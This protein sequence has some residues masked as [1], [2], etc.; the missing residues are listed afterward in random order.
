MKLNRTTLVN[1]IFALLILLAGLVMTVNSFGQTSTPCSNPSQNIYGLTGN[2][3]IYEI[4]MTTGV[5]GT[6]VKNNTYSGNSPSK[7]NGMGYNYA[8][9]KF[10]YFKRNVGTTPQ[11][12]VSFS[13]ATNTVTIL[14]S[15]TCADEVHTGCVNYAGTGYYTIDIQGNL[16]Y[17][18][19]T[20]NT[21]TFITSNIVDQYNLDVDSCIR[22]Q[23]AG[24]MAMDGY[25]HIYLVTSSNSNYGLF[26]FPILP[27]TAVAKITVNR[28]VSPYTATP[29]G[30]SFAGIAFNPTGQIYM[31]TKTGNRLYRLNNDLSLTF[32]AAMG[33]SDIGND[34]TS[35]SFPFLVLPVTWE[36]FDV[37][38][39]RDNT[40][41][42]SWTVT[43][44][45]NKGFYVEHSTDGKAWESLGFIASKGSNIETVQSYTYSHAITFNGIHYYRIRQVDIDGR[46]SY[47]EVRSI[48]LKNNLQQVSIWPNPAT[49][50]LRIVTQSGDNNSKARIFDLSG[51]M[52]AQKQLQ[53][54]SVNTMNIGSL[55]T[56]TYIVKIESGDGISYN[57]KISKQ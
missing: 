20:T 34:L 39:Q 4:N 56:G 33:V 46:E 47:S 6:V 23:N 54:A 8:N 37:S 25:G 42:I 15:S 26:E 10:Y 16:N 14:A 53:P 2:G 9:Q 40:V 45:Q 28:I 18:N 35:C 19:I 57:Q 50:Q 27:T 29:T 3:E 44:Q 43:E 48:D 24:D 30:Q 22:I 31:A 41:G 38:L 36:K 49:D 7:A 13:P 12:F 55:P 17:Y 21:W 32:I 11:E 51:R 1:A 52:I 5:T